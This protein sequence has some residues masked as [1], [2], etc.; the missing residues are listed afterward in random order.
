MH[1]SVVLFALGKYG[2][3]LATH[4]LVLPFGSSHVLVVSHQLVVAQAQAL[5]QPHTPTGQ[6]DL[7][8]MAN[9]QPWLHQYLAVTRTVGRGVAYQRGM[10]AWHGVDAD[11]C[12]RLDRRDH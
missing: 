9:D 10:T 6:A 8:E 7:G 1:Q 2:I 3:R 5:V 11:P 12:I 4:G